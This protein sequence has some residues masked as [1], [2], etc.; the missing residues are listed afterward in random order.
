MFYHT[1]IHKTVVSFLLPFVQ[2]SIYESPVSLGRKMMKDCNLH[3]ADIYRKL[4]Q[5]HIWLSLFYA[6]SE[7]ME[8]ASDYR[9]SLYENTLITESPKDFVCRTAA[10]DGRNTAAIIISRILSGNESVFLAIL[11]ISFIFFHHLTALNTHYDLFA[12]LFSVLSGLYLIQICKK[13]RLLRTHY[14]SKHIK[15]HPAI[16]FLIALSLLHDIIVVYFAF[17]VREIDLWALYDKLL[18]A[19]YCL[20]PIIGLLFIVYFKDTYNEI[21]LT[22]L[23]IVIYQK[24]LSTASLHGISTSESILQW[25][26]HF[27]SIQTALYVVLTATCLTIVHVGNKNGC[28]DKKGDFGN[29]NIKRT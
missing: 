2:A 23:F 12:V 16:C 15:F 9:E 25:T 14:I 24:A 7:R 29:H 4:R 11:F 3:D 8:I 28:S 1:T 18:K 19:D 22:D 6:R 27:I 5:L 21:L 26:V 17:F 10:E 13:I 20:I